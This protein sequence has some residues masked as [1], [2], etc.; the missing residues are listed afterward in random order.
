M[1]GGKLYF[2]YIRSCISGRKIETLYYMAFFY[3]LCCL[4]GPGLIFTIWGK[5]QRGCMDFLHP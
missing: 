3:R 5:G 4:M 2:K 1:H